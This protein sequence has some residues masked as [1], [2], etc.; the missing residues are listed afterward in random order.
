MYFR[1]QLGACGSRLI[2]WGFELEEALAPTQQECCK[3][4]GYAEHYKQDAEGQGRE[5]ASAES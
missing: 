3:C 1:A 2:F 4:Q 5:D